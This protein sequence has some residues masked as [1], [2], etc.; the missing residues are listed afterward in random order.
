MT[1]ENCLEH[2]LFIICVIIA[3]CSRV[4]DICGVKPFLNIFCSK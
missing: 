4:P 2:A 1:T 3:V